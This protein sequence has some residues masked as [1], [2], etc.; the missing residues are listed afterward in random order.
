MQHQ[1]LIK[2]LLSR[3]V[4]F[5]STLGAVGALLGLESLDARLGHLCTR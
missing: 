2:S 1:S 3:K 4:A 5:G